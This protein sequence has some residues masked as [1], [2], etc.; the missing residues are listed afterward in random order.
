MMKAALGLLALLACY[1]QEQQNLHPVPRSPQW[2][3]YPGADGPGAGKHIVLIAADQEYRSEQSLPM[4][5]K[6][7]SQ[8]HGFHCTVLFS[9]NEKG[10]VDPSQKIKWQDESVVHNIPGLE[11]LASADLVVLFSRLITLPADQLAYIYQYLDSGKPIIGFRTANHGF[12][13]FDYKKEGQ[14]VNFGVDVL[15]GSFRS[16]HGRWHQDSTEGMIVAEQQSHPILRGVRDIWGPSD[17]YRT[18][19]EDGELSAE[20]TA[21]VMGQ[22]LMTRDQGSPINAELIALPVA[23]VKNWTGNLGQTGRVFHSTM[24]SGKDFENAGLRRL[25]INAVYWCLGIEDQINPN[26]DVDVVGTFEPL[27]SGFNY[28]ELG[29]FPHPPA[30]YR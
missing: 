9:L 20:C 17:V 26:S 24:G 28:Q 19:P 30:Y 7:L 21:L 5:A 4:L 18:Y 13:G 15:G 12:I 3:V 29:V 1:S 10:E 25:A 14:Q 11:H 23:W 8:R 6:I 16:H 2:L 22:P 27:P